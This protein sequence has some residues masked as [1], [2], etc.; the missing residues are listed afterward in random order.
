MKLVPVVL[1]VGGQT[2][3]LGRAVLGDEAERA[4]LELEPESLRQAL[5]RVSAP[6]DHLRSARFVKDLERMAER[7]R[8]V[9]E[10]PKKEKWHQQMRDQLASILEELERLQRTERGGHHTPGSSL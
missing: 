4:W 9:L 5:R 3:E 2:I 10:D 7:S 1:R 8:R 6:E